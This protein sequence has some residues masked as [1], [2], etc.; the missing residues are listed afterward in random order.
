MLVRKAWRC[1]DGGW[2]V[3]DMAFWQQAATDQEY[4][5][6]KLNSSLYPVTFMAQ[7]NGKGKYYPTALSR[8]I[9][10]RSTR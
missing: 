1:G 3:Y 2:V 8:T 7:V 4:D 5:W 6:P 9:Q 10:V